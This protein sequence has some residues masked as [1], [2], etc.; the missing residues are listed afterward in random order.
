MV[1]ILFSFIFSIL[2]IILPYYLFMVS[3]SS[4]DTPLVWKRSLRICAR[5]TTT[6]RSPFPPISQCRHSP[7]LHSP[8]QQPPHL[9]RLRPLPLLLRLQVRHLLSSYRRLRLPRDQHLRPL[10]QRTPRPLRHRVQR[11]RLPLR[12]DRA[13]AVLRLRLSLP[14]PHRLQVPISFYGL[15]VRCT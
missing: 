8:H 3:S 13:S 9:L 2:Y 4:L 14:L 15:T 6:P 5:P 11:P 12:A 7:H 10:P 1:L